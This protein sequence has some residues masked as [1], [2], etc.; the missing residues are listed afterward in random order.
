MLERKESHTATHWCSISVSY[1]PSPLTHQYCQMCPCYELCCLAIP[2]LATV[3]RNKCLSWGMPGTPTTACETFIWSLYGFQ[4]C[5]IASLVRVIIFHSVP[6]GKGNAPRHDDPQMMTNTASALKWHHSPPQSM[7]LSQENM[8]YGW[9]MGLG[10][11]KQCTDVTA[12]SVQLWHRIALEGILFFTK[13]TRYAE[14]VQ[15][16]TKQEKLSKT[17]V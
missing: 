12:I 14:E 6:V 10:Y 15:T 8:C 16:K 9:W 4:E 17:K 5:T 3:K 2:S 13:W 1:L 7:H 11:D